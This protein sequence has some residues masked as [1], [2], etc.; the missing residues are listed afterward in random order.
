MIK[1][2]ATKNEDVKRC[3]ALLQLQRCRL[4]EWL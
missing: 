3:T 2:L 1:A 4:Q